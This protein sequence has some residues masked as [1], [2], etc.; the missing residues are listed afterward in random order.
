MKKILG[1]VLAMTMMLSLAACASTPAATTAATTAAGADT[2]AAADTAAAT[3]AAGSTDKPLIALCL[4]SMDNPLMLAFQ[5]TFIARF[6]ADY[7]VQ[8]S[9]ADNNPNNQAT[10]I[11]NFTTMG[12]KIIFT[13]PIESSSLVPKLEAARAA[14]VL[15]FVAGTEPGESARDGVAKMD[16]FLAGA[17]CA[18]MAKEWVDANYPDAADG[19]IEAGFL[20]SALSEDDTVRCA[21]LKMAA[22]P[23]LKNAAGEFIDTEGNVVDDSGKIANPVY[24]PQLNFVVE[25][26]GSMFQA[27]QTATQNMLTTNPDIKVV[28]AYSSDGASGASQAIMDEVSKTGA[29]AATYATFGVGMFGPEEATLIASEKGEGVFRGALAFGGGNLPENM[30]NIVEMMLKGEDYPV[31]TWDPLAAVTVKDGALVRV[32]LPNSGVIQ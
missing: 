5:E 7:D 3:T 2:T 21:G 8:V 4:P 10:Q 25:A 16:Q 14:G 24:I 11:E 9:G 32:E 18:K 20:T 26:D 15:V 28:L 31:V 19:S 6:G 17:Y 12:A 1:I 23:F 29:D 30:A 27:G 22:E 13:M